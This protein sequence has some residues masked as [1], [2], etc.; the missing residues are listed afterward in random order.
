MFVYLVFEVARQERRIGK[1]KT[2]GRRV[3][4][5]SVSGERISRTVQYRTKSARLL[6]PLFGRF[7]CWFRTRVAVGT[8][9]FWTRGILASKSD[10]MRFD[11]LDTE[12]E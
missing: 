4:V 3:Y 12:P 8:A 9:G 1:P 5:K 10:E 11:R 7:E 6:V 2:R